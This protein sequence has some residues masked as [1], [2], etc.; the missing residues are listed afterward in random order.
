MK[1]GNCQR[2][3]S[4][5]SVSAGEKETET[6]G[7][8]AFQA[9]HVAENP[10]TIEN[11]RNKL[12]KLQKKYRKA[13]NSLQVAVQSASKSGLQKNVRLSN[14]RKAIKNLIQAEADDD[15]KQFHRWFFV[16]AKAYEEF[17]DYLENDDV[18]G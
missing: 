18:A 3:E 17:E 9:T 1:N 5:R 4:E 16:M 2:S 10:F 6:L 15:E 13:T 14:L 7:L 8:F 11:E 12:K